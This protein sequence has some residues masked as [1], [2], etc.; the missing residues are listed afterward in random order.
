MSSSLYDISSGLSVHGLG[1]IPL[2]SHLLLYCS[3]LIVYNIESHELI[4]V[5]LTLT[6]S[7]SMLYYTEYTVITLI[8][9][10]YSMLLHFLL[11]RSSMITLSST[12]ITASSI[13]NITV[14]MTHMS[15][16]VIIVM[17]F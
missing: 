9:H 15:I 1:L 7:Q 14:S 2:S 16:T 3:I 4:S 10:L 17:S 13:I 6:L 8:I 5:Q 11:N 12:L